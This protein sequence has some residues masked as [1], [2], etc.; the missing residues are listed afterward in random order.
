MLEP[1]FVNSRNCRQSFEILDLLEGGLIRVV[2]LV[3]DPTRS[4]KALI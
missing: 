1:E 4:D 3:I 2:T